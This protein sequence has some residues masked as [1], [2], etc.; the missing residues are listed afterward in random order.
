M[1]KATRMFWL[2]AEMTHLNPAEGKILEIASVITD[3]NLNELDRFHAVIHQS[4]AILMTMHP[5]SQEHH[6]KSG[7][8]DEC[9][10]SVL[11]EENVEKVLIEMI[12]TWFGKDEEGKNIKPVLCGNSIH[13]DRRFLELHMPRFTER[14]H[15]RMIDVST[16]K[17]LAKR[18]NP[19]IYEA[20]K[21]KETHRAFEDIMESINE[22]GHYWRN[23]NKLM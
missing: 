9:R 7:L 10:K 1:N 20:F 5:W 12:D 6:R 19:S 21:K 18:W 2:D 11:T 15:Y 3:G 14:S 8:I 23:L 17:E 4:E 16:L 13:F 22:L